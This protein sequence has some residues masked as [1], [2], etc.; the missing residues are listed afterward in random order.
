VIML[1]KRRESWQLPESAVTPREVFEDRRRFIQ[2]AS[3]L[4]LGAIA[5]GLGFPMR[6]AMAAPLATVHPAAYSAEALGLDVTAK[7]HATSYNNFYEFGTGKSDPVENAQ[8]FKP[9]PWTVEVSG[10]AA[11]TGTFSYEDLVSPH[12]L[13]ERVYRFRCVE[14]W[15]MVVPWV[16]IPLADMLKRFEPTSGAKYVAFETLYDPERMPGQNRSV[17]PWPYVEGL[18][19]DEAMNPLTMMVVGMYGETLP[20]QNGAPLRL[21]VPWKY[22]FKS[23]KSIVKISFTEEEPKTTWNMA[24]SR[25]YGFYSNVNPEKSHPRWSQAKERVIGSGLFPERRPTPMFNGYGEQVAHLYDGMDL[26][27]FF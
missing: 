20:N 2:G 13:E 3:A 24:N 8:D 26:K 11:N 1:I 17:I 22:G 14:A 16:G 23:I 6:D 21:I 4:G 7:E 12:K 9:L 15:S 19:I 5:G 27:K 25:E 18:R 10:H